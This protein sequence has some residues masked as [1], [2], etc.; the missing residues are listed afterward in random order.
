M[1]FL[2]SNVVFELSGSVFVM[3]IHDAS[4]NGEVHPYALQVY[5][6]KAPAD[7]VEAVCGPLQLYENQ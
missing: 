4:R 3:C 6:L 7:D 5:I 2:I 1:F